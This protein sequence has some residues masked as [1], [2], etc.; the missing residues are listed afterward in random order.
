M[1]TRSPF[2]PAT[3]SHRRPG[4]PGDGRL[5]TSQGVGTPGVQGR[6]SPSANSKVATPIGPGDGRPDTQ[7]WSYVINAYQFTSTRSAATVVAGGCHQL[8][9]PAPRFN[10]LLA[11][12]PRR[13]QTAGDSRP[14]AGSSG[15][16]RP[17]QSSGPPRWI[18]R[19]KLV[20]KLTVRVRFPSPAPNAKSVAIHT[21]WTPFPIWMGTRR[22]QKSALV[23]LPRAISQA[24][25]TV[26]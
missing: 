3:L 12:C 2:S 6:R 9:S 25:R 10:R 21:N 11:P 15:C 5:H 22:H 26:S 13:A 24:G 7:G 1:A 14:I 16:P 19:I 20:P 17:A 4:P 8:I 18:A 23:P